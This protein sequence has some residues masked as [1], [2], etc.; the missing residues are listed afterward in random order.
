MATLLI[1][2]DRSQEGTFKTPDGQLI[3]YSNRVLR[4]ATDDGSDK[5]FSFGYAGYE[6]KLKSR[7]LCR[8]LGLRNDDNFRTLDNWLS[9]HLNKPVELLRSPV[10]NALVV[11]GFKAVGTSPNKS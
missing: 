9:E 7:D 6:E 4:L 1:G 10:N 11:T 5:Q 2:F 3:P 8:Y